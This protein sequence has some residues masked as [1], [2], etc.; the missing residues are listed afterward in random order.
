M[1]DPMP[2]PPAQPPVQ[3]APPPPPASNRLGL[4]ILILLLLV[5]AM[6][7][8]YGVEEFSYAM[9]RGELRAK[10]DVAAAELEQ[11][12]AN[13]KLVKLADTS[14]AFRDAA[15]VVELSVVHINTESVR[16]VPKEA[17]DEWG[18]RVPRGKGPQRTR[19]QGSGVIVDSAKGYILTNFHVIQDASSVNVRLA[20]GT[21]TADVTLVGYDVLTDLAVLKIKSTK[22]K[23]IEWGDSNSLEVGDWVLAIGNPYGLDRTVTVGVL[24]AKE[25]R[26]VGSTPYQEF[27]QTDAAVNPGN[28][29]GP[30]VDVTGKLIGINTAI[31]GESFQG[32]SFAIPGNTAH[33]VYEKII[34]GGRV[35]RG[36]FGVG[37]ENLT[38]EE[39]DDPDGK[40]AVG[41][42][43]TR[44]VPGSPAAISGIR[45][46]DILEEWD[47][48]PVTDAME[49]TLE[50]ART[51]IGKQ[52]KCIVLRDGKRIP[53]QVTIGQRP[54]VT[55]LK[56]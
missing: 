42:R 44:V 46:G 21:R 16:V 28:S 45:Q 53:L 49:F 37:L 18:F 2:F 47:G 32:I 39:D 7:L 38:P 13:A 19:G 51:A 56:R 24:S 30:L 33:D 31:I 48:K 20:D 15:K 43:V 6:V 14:L 9:K 11:L 23:A 29:G 54:D 52:I 55:E 50:I 27:L 35:A 3:Y 12:G 26:G 36:W 22:L 41:L 5:G 8:P 34:A 40:A 25:R 10:S 1:H 17:D 4:L